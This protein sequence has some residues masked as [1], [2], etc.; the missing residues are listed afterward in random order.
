M[1]GVQTC[2]L[3]IYES[4]ADT[5]IDTTKV[6]S[7]VS[8]SISI[9]DINNPGFNMPSA[10][11]NEKF[12]SRRCRATEEFAIWFTR[13]RYLCVLVRFKLLPYHILDSRRS[14]RS[15]WFCCVYGL[16]F[17]FLKCFMFIGSVYHTTQTCDW[18]HYHGCITVPRTNQGTV[19]PLRYYGSITVPRIRYGTMDRSRYHGSITIP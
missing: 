15:R 3:P 16:S 10:F 12:E 1:T 4:I 2:A 7:I 13:W 5:D 6:S 14:R 17:V 18:Y 8:M 19:D 11:F 9:F